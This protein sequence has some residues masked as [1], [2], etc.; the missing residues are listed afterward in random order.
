VNDKPF[1]CSVL[2]AIQPLIAKGEIRAQAWGM[3]YDR[4]ATED[5]GP[6]RYGT[7]FTCQERKLVLA[8]LEG[9]EHVNLWRTTMGF[10]LTAE[11]GAAQSAKAL[12]C[13]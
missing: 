7:V 1:Q 3:L 12:P 8:P 5:G 4:V 9:P 2:A 13:T 11:E 6:Q 10:A